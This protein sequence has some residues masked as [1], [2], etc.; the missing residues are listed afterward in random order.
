MTAPVIFEG[1][2][3]LTPDLARTAASSVRLR[4]P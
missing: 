2:D 4:D 1:L 3:E